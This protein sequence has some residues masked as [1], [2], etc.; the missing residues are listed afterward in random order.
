MKIL[1]KL[2]ATL[3]WILMI[4]CVA[5]I[6]YYVIGI[7]ERTP[8]TL[9]KEDTEYLYYKEYEIYN[10]DSCINKYHKPI[11]YDGEIVDKLSH[12]QGIPGKGGHWVYRTYIKYDGDKEHVEFGVHFYSNHEIVD[13]VKIKIEFYPYEKLSILNNE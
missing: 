3:F 6:M 7:I 11:I 13:K 2:L 12:I 8:D 9:V 10:K 4:G 1:D 5:I